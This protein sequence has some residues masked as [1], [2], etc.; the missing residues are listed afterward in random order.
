[1]A[2]WA[3]ASTVELLGVHIEPNSK[4][5]RYAASTIKAPPDAYSAAKND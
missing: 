2:S 5:T 3:A 1:M 4:A